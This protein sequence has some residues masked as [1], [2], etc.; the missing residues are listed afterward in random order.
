MLLCPPL[1]GIAGDDA[2]SD[3]ASMESAA[4][5]A[6]V[7]AAAAAL[8]ASTRAATSNCAVH[9]ASAREYQSVL[10][11]NARAALTRLARA[12]AELWLHRKV[13]AGVPPDVLR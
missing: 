2:V 5:T 12:S 9:L 8:A 10:A 11:T 7:A 3:A 13:T 6:R 1:A 4:A